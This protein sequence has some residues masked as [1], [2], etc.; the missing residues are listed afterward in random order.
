MSTSS[1]LGT[2]AAFAIGC[3]LAFTGLT[4]WHRVQSNQAAQKNTCQQVQQL[5]RVIYA[6]VVRSGQTLGRKG[7]A[8]YAYYRAHPVELAAARAEVRNEARQFS[9]HRCA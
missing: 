1:V 3:L 7:T 8:G 4:V 5:E 9:G 2:I 6:Q